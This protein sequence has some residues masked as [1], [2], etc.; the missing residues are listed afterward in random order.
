M[1][2]LH[3]TAKPILSPQ[4][5]VRL[6]IFLASMVSEATSFQVYIG[7]VERSIGVDQVT[8]LQI[9]LFFSE[10]YPFF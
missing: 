4:V 10:S 7:P 9:A 3:C 6:L 2:I 5:I 1:A 8:I